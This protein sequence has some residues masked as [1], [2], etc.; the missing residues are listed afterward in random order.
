MTVHLV[1]GPARRPRTELR[2]AN[3]GRVRTT[4]AAEQ[5]SPNGRE[6]KHIRI[7]RSLANIYAIIW[8][9]FCFSHI[10]FEPDRVH[11]GYIFT[12]FYSTG[13]GCADTRGFLGKTLAATT[14]HVGCAERLVCERWVCTRVGKS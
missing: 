11:L 3:N 6:R 7:Y 5:Y 8:L 12:K 2:N 9:W 1:G 14:T 4:A 13:F 10:Q